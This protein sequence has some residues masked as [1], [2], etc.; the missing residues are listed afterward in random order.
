METYKI[1][2]IETLSK[3]VE[4]T[5]ENGDAALD[6]AKQMYGSSQVILSADDFEEV[7]FYELPKPHIK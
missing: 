4:I 3:T 2:I 7:E 1:K 5:A 6:E